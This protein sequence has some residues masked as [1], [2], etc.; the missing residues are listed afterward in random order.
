VSRRTA[1]R[2]ARERGWETIGEA[3][4]LAVARLQADA[5]ITIGV[6]TARKAAGIGPLG[7][8]DA[9]SSVE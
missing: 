6:S 5:L 4:F 8:L 3:E 1:W 9:L 7:S 2:I